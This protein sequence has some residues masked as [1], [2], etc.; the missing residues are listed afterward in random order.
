MKIKSLLLASSLIAVAALFAYCSKEQQPTLTN[1]NTVK[2]EVVERGVCNVVVATNNCAVNICGAQNNANVC[3]ALA[4][5]IPLVGNDFI[6]NGAFRNYVLN[7]PA[8]FRA[9]LNGL[10]NGPNPSISVAS[11]NIVKVY[12]LIPNFATTIPASVVVNINNNCVPL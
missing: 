11:G 7:T 2:P 9:T 8:S 4:G 10:P 3:G 1:E 6:P 12:P 5:G